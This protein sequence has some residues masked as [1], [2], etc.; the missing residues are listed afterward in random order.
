MASDSSQSRDRMCA[1]SH[2]SV[3]FAGVGKKA[4]ESS[5]ESSRSDVGQRCLAEMLGN[6]GAS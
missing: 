4:E 5:S 6:S 2:G 3:R 1:P